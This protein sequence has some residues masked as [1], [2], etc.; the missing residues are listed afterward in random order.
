MTST[1]NYGPLLPLNLGSDLVSL[2]KVYGDDS[3][4][5][6]NKAFYGLFPGVASPTREF[7]LSCSL[8]LFIL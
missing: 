6:L 2:T 8:L 4:P 5:A 7:T 1:L 3:L